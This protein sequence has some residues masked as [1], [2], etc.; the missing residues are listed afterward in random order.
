MN[1]PLET[2]RFQENHRWT[3]THK[4]IPFEIIHSLKEE[5]YYFP[6]GFWTYYVFISEWRLREHFK[7]ISTPEDFDKFFIPA[8][9]EDTVL[10]HPCY[11]YYKHPVADLYFHRG[12]TFCE[13][14]APHRGFR[15]LKVGCDYLHLDDDMLAGLLSPE[16]IFETDIVRTI[17]S[18]LEWYDRVKQQRGTPVVE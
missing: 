2:P 9:A 12:I 6:Q 1:T 18:L 5:D 3:G 7:V 15:I 8:L 10:G 11:D 16:Y 4:D 17:D 13:L 14:V